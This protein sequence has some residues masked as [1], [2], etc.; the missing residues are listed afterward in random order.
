[1]FSALA[2]SLDQNQLAGWNGK[3]MSGILKLAEALPH[4]QLTSLSLANN[5]LC[6]KYAN[7]HS[8]VR[9]TYTAEGINALCDALKSTTTLT[10]LNLDGNSL[11]GYKGDFRM[12]AYFSDASLRRQESFGRELRRLSQNS[13]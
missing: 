4:L 2:R 1:M 7:E 12:H 10:S 8:N 13:H 11:G 3:D 6:G 5:S 9:G